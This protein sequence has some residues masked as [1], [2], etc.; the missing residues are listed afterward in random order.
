[1][2]QLWIAAVMEDPKVP[3]CYRRG[4]TSLRRVQSFIDPDNV[5]IK[6][7]RDELAVSSA[8]LDAAESVRSRPRYR[9]AD[10]CSAEVGG[11]VCVHKQTISRLKERLEVRSR[12]T[13]E[14]QQ[15]EMDAKLEMSR[16]AVLP[17]LRISL[18]S[19][20]L[21]LSL[22]LSLFLSL[23]LPLS[24]P[25]FLSHS[26]TL[27]LSHVP[28]MRSLNATA[29]PTRFTA[30]VHWHWWR[31]LQGDREDGGVQRRRREAG[32]HGD[33]AVGGDGQDP[34][35]SAGARS[36]RWGAAVTSVERAATT[37]TITSSMH[38]CSTNSSSSCVC[39]ACSEAEGD[40]EEVTSSHCRYLSK[41]RLPSVT[42]AGVTR[43]WRQTLYG[44]VVQWFAMLASPN[45]T[46]P[47]RRTAGAPDGGSSTV[48]AMP[49][50]LPSSSPPRVLPRSN[51]L[52]PDVD[53]EGVDVQLPPPSLPEVRAPPRCSSRRVSAGRC[54]VAAAARSRGAAVV[55]P[56]A[57]CAEDWEAFAGVSS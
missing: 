8:A 16:C 57:V 13:V 49:T 10:R 44:D 4:P 37:T 7:L 35:P 15:G 20:A 11:R 55:C 6:R 27:I 17:L 48:P 24:L 41:L 5:E 39:W 18:P 2:L 56:A 25:L 21:S 45:N 33:A 3:L 14:A 31:V 34:G 26:C 1:M 43:L 23:C 30:V 32:A 42:R 52:S 47:R 28:F 9:V 22:S 12:E 38:R 54:Y 29:A 46:S 51:A 19:Q 50:P 40:A 53:A 36:G